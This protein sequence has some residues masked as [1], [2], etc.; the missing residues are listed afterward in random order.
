[1]EATI[2]AVLAKVDAVI[3]MTV[4]GR[5][6]LEQVLPVLKAGKPVYIG[7]PMAASLEDVIEIFQR[8]KQARHSHLFLLS[9]SIQSR[10]HRD[11][12]SS[13]SR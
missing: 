5:T 13:R 9:A 12:K 2:E 6:H 3:L 11:A 1:M 7:R 10:H 8:A 4:D